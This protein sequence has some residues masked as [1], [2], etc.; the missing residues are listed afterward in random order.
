MERK[1]IYNLHYVLSKVRFL[2]KTN[3]RAKVKGVGVFKVLSGRDCKVNF[4]GYKMNMASDRLKLFFN[5]HKCVTCG[6][7]GSFIAMERVNN[8]EGYHFNMYSINNSNEEV[9][10]TKDHIIPKSKGGNDCMNNYQTMCIVCNNE[11]ENK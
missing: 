7:E 3:R 10:M 5:S 2:D 4:E 1:G 6:I 11:K 8:S 9:L